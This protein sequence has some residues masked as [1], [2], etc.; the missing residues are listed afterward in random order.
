M[1]Q[2]SVPHWQGA[3]WKNSLARA[4]RDPA[5]LIDYLQLPQQWLPAALAASHQ[6]PL[7]VPRGFAARMRKGDPNDPLLLQVL[8]LHRELEQTAGFSVDPVGDLQ[9][10]PVPGLLQKYAGR[11]LL[12]TTG[13]CAIHCRY[14]FRR[15]F[16]YSESHIDSQ[17]WQ[18]MIDAITADTSIHEVILSG[19]D[20]LT[21][22]DE[23]LLTLASQLDQIP[24]LTRLRLH[25][26]LPIV[27][28]ERIT[29]TLLQ[30][31]SRLRLQIVLV[32]H[33]NHANELDHH[34]NQA[35]QSLRN[36]GITL[37]NQTVLLKRINDSTE[38]LSRLSEAL[39]ANGVLPYYLHQLD[40]VQGAGHFEVSDQCAME[41]LDHCRVHLPGYL[42]P[43]LVREVQGTAYKHPLE[44][45]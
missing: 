44:G 28:P 33:V 31:L 1:I 16:P 35:L 32:V 2:P 10:M 3:D 22:S 43:K 17:N 8:P 20:P 38:A 7:R 9:A 5:E 30:G 37:L 45:L 42:V 6:F 40:R 34:V 26:R 15:H 21:L 13:A 4:I 19:G 25:T 12:I 41:L 39:F 29:H 36:Y 14:C 18:R 27:V 24:H 11:V 23:R